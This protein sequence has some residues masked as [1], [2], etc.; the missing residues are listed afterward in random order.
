MKFLDANN[1]PF[2]QYWFQMDGG[3]LLARALKPP[4]YHYLGFKGKKKLWTRNYEVAILEGETFIKYVGKGRT[5]WWEV[6]EVQSGNLV[7]VSDTQGFPPHIQ[8][9]V[10]RRKAAKNEEK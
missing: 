2:K 4:Y 3:W 1:P 6:H 8:A 10:E 7:K 9:F 5:R